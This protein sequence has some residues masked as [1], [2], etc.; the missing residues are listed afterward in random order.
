MPPRSIWL[1]GSLAT[2]A[3]G[4]VLAEVVDVFTA[5]V[6]PPGFGLSVAFGSD[7]QELDEDSQREWA[8]WAEPA[9]R[10]LL[11]IPPFKMGD[12]AIPAKWRIYRPEMTF[13]GDPSR[14]AKLLASEVRYEV[15]GS[16]QTAV[17]LGGQWKSGGVNTA[18][19]RKH[20][21]SGVFAITCLPLWSLTVLD[22]RDELKKWLSMLHELSGQPM[23][24]VDSQDSADLFHPTKDHFA[25]MLHLCGGR[26]QSSDEAVAALVD[27]PVLTLPAVA[28]RQCLH[29]LD[30][31]G[32]SGA[33]QLT[34]SGRK[35][36]FDSPY[37]G[38]ARAMERAIT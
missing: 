14:L 8:T 19:F 23:T 33:G 4:K 22:H 6:L 2:H 32:L 16:L 5:Y 10:T 31:A 27:S 36:L 15:A 28:A 29:Q 37:A 38:Y 12:Y 30:V 3:R 24:K 13:G 7:F 35:M 21:D 11:L 17:D 1:L 18:Y 9:G 20:P 26:F 25:M 34:E